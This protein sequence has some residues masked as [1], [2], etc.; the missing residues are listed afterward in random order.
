MPQ[1]LAASRRA[2]RLLEEGGFLEAVAVVN[3]GEAVLAGPSAP[4]MADELTEEATTALDE[5]LAIL[6]DRA[7]RR[8]LHGAP[9]S[10]LLREIQRTQA[11]LIA[12]G[13]H[14]HRRVADILLGG[15]SGELLHVAPC[16]VL[17]AR[18][19]GDV[20]GFPH[21]IVVGI[22]GS[23]EGDAALAVAQDLARRFGSDLRAVTALKGKHLD[24]AHVHLR[25]AFAEE[26]DADPVDALVEASRGA[27]L[28][29]VGSR[30]LHGLRALGS[31]SERVAYRTACSTLVVR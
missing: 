16:S 14:G 5:A 22:D 21:S 20:D 19:A 8:L 12:L 31:V 13:S 10:E 7:Q 30:G 27:D 25:H 3:L 11:T 9:V 26:I 6:G 4:R 1:G 17:I 18:D 23:L 15:T 24:L 29:I 28:V 2:A